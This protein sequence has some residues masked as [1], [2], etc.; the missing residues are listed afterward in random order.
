LTLDQQL[1]DFRKLIEHSEKALE[2]FP[3]QGILYFFHGEGHLR[4]GNYD[5]AIASLEQGRRLSGSN[6]AQLADIQAALGEA[7]YY[8]GDVARSERVFQEALAQNAVRPEALNR[9]ASVLIARKEKLEKAEQI[10]TQLVRDHPGNVAFLDTYSLVLYHRG[11]FG[12]ARKVIEQAI[13]KDN[14][15]AVHFEHYG[16]ILYKLGEVDAAVMQ[17]EKARSRNTNNELLNKKI[18]NR[19]IYE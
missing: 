8:Q 9:Y 18:A 12:E 11:K 17:W 7:Y 10:A 5:E 15:T 3:N 1:G 13:N 2:I 14:A 19:K 6:P 16:D 4:A